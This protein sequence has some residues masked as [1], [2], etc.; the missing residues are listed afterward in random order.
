MK[1]KIAIIGAGVMGQAIAKGLLEK[2]IVIPEDL[3]LTNVMFNGLEVFVHTGVTVTGSNMRAF[4]FADIIIFAVKPQ[5]IDQVFLEAKDTLKKNQLLISIAAGVSL[6]HMQKILGKKKIVRV[7]PNLCAQVGQSLSCW[8]A[9]TQVE[10]DDK[11]LV[12]QLL[13]GIGKDI[14]LL[15]ED[16]ID[17]VTPLSGSGPAYVFYLAELLEKEAIAA[18]I[19]KEHAHT[20]ATQT[21]TGASAMLSVSDIRFETLRKEVSS[22]GGV[23]EKAFSVFAEKKFDHL[24]HE[25]IKKAWEKAKELDK[26][27]ENLLY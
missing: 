20:L 21:I 16:H 17:R 15:R 9:N 11:K 6:D 23:T 7:M 25:A 26:K 10:N 3:M 2:K 22:K 27:R 1:K 19:T 8:I 13:S 18:G 12:R 24:F 4:Q 5:I 14:E